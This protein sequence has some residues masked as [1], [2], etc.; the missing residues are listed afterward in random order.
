MRVKPKIRGPCTHGIETLSDN[1]ALVKRAI[2][3]QVAA[4]ARAGDF[5]ADGASLLGFFVKLVDARR[6][7]ARSG[8]Y[9]LHPSLVEHFTETI[10]VSSQE[11][12]FHLDSD[13]FR[14]VQCRER[15]RILG[16]RALHLVLNNRLGL[17][18]SYVAEKQIVFEFVD[19]EI[20]EPERRDDNIFTIELH[21]IEAAKSGGILVLP[22]ALDS[23]VVAFDIVGQF[24][25][26]RGRYG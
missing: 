21:K 20:A 15:L 9:L 4:P 3:D 22:A 18:P 8:L 23:Y 17:A 19:D 12:F 14:L 7:D 16:F 25:H 10:E 2:E 6:G 5:A 1:V 26:P 11:R 24:G 13:F